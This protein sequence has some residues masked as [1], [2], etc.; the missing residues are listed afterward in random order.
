MKM[1]AEGYH[2]CYNVQAAVVGRH[3]LVP[4]TEV[5]SNAS[6]QGALA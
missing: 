2:Q 3:Q 6:D 4:A 1:S 5:T